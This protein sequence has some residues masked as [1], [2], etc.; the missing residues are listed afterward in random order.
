[1]SPIDDE[2]RAALQ[3]RATVVPPAPDPLAGIERR[4]TRMQRNRL[5]ASVAGSVLAVAAIA[6]AVPLL[7]GTTGGEPDSARVASSQ[8]TPRPTTDPTGTPTGAP[9]T[10]PTQA[11]TTTPSK[12]PPTS[13]ALRPDSPWAYRGIPLDELGP[14]TVEAV[15]QQVASARGVELSAVALSPLFGQTYEPSA[16]TE[17]VYV[18]QVG[19]EPRWGVARTGE[20]GPELAVD[21][22]LADGT[23]ALLAALPG[24]EV[25][26]LLVVASPEV[27]EI[28]YGP[29]DASEFAAMTRLDDGVAIGPLEGDPATDSVRVLDRSGATLFRGP[30]PDVEAAPQDGTAPANLLSDWPERGTADPELLTAAER[31][32]AQ[33]LGSPDAAVSSRPLFGGSDD[34]GNAYVLLQAWVP[35]DDAYTFG[36][37]VRPGGEAVPFL[38]PKTDPEARVLALL[39]EAA[40]GQSVDTLVVVPQPGTGQVLY[41]EAASELRPVGEGQSFDGVVLVDRAR[42]ASGDRLRLLDGDGDLDAPTFDGLVS[43]LLCGVRGCG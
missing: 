4:A 17:L 13:F 27:G 41:G 39:V 10:A 19:G 2:L 14:G 31:A 9:T 5:A 21:E 7:G 23:T 36:Y 34:A 38:G 1:M 29:D 20:A 15:R 3:R 40:P 24:D 18:A 42:G 28:S 37:T 43:D 12:V 16:S 26:R 22:A 25:A 32:F 35:G 30:A 6:T 33:A 8:P 11:P